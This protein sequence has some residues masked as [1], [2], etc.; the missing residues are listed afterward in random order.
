MP[1]AAVQWRLGFARDVR[2]AVRLLLERPGFALIAILT[3]A[4]GIGATTSIFTVVEAVLLRPLP[5][6]DPDRLVQVRI[7]GQGGAAFPLPDTDFLAWRGTNAAAE[8][9]P[10]S[11]VEPVNATRIGEPER[12]SAA[13]VSDQFFRL[14]GV[15]PEIGR[16]FEA[17]ED[18]PGAP[19]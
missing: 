5:F 16:M 17:G 11:D 2:H 10:L 4:L 13:I 6:P 7:N 12:L 14:L 15:S 9:A 8:R 1:A 18:R 19:R 3:L